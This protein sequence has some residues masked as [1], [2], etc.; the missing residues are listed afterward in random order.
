MKIPLTINVHKIFIIET[1]VTKV[2]E[3]QR[4]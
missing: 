3:Q 2:F 4:K 1:K